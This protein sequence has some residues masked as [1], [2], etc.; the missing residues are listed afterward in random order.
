MKKYLFMAAAAAMVSVFCA[1]DNEKGNGGGGITPP[2]IEKDY[3]TLEAVEGSFVIAVK[4]EGEVC[5][6][7]VFPGSYNL[8]EG[9][10]DWS[11]VVD[12]K[13]L[14]MEPVGTINDKEWDGWYKV[15]VP[16]EGD[17]L[18]GKPVQLK[19][20]GTFDWLYQTGDSASWTIKAGAVSIKAGYSGE[21]DLTFTDK[22]TPV[23]LISA[24]WKD[25]AS[26]CNVQEGTI[27]FNATAPEG[28]L[29][30]D[31]IYVVG[32]FNGWTVDGTPMTKQPDGTWTAEAT[33]T[34]SG[35]YKYVLNAS[36][37][38]EELA[39]IEEGADCANTI[40]NR[41]LSSTIVNDTIENFKD[42]TATR[43]KE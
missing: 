7:I 30:E 24:K 14:R 33:G 1:C 31:V 4:F 17:T 34:V 15:V 3:P 40:N 25:G 21:S 29:D 32:D 43:C 22:S 37:D 16:M 11:T 6:E 27:T 36:W 20:D 18:Q 42:R 10:T 38:Y 35:G 13:M 26:P 9:S 23:C 39:A 28:L 12:D 2:V 41:T 8:V 5:N 19:N